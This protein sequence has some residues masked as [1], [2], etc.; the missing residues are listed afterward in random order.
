MP[1]ARLP[2]VPQRAMNGLASRVVAI[3]TS[4]AVAKARLKPTCVKPAR[5]MSTRGAVEKNT[6]NVPMAAA[7]PSV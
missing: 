7:K 2:A 5:S 3:I 4:A 1:R 6:K